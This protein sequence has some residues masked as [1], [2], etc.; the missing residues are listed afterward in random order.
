MSIRIDDNYPCAK[1][2]A[3]LGHGYGLPFGSFIPFAF[4]P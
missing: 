4:G 1:K 3:W 2:Q